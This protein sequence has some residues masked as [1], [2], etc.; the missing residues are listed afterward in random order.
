MVATRIPADIEHEAPV[1]SLVELVYQNEAG[2]VSRRRVEVVR[3]SH[4]RNGFTYLRA[5]C[6][7]REEER[8]FRA[9]RIRDW[10]VVECRRPV[11][12]KPVVT[13]V[14]LTIPEAPIEPVCREGP[15]VLAAEAP[16]AVHPVPAAPRRRR[17]GWFLSMLG[18]GLT[19]TLVRALLGEPAVLNTVPAPPGPVVLPA[20]KPAPRPL[21]VP[22]PKPAARPGAHP[23]PNPMQPRRVAPPN[24]EGVEARQRTFRAATGIASV[25]LE[26]LYEGADRNGDGA[27]DWTELAV[28]QSWLDRA[29]AYRANRLALRPDEFLAEGGGDCEDWALFSCGLLRYW[30]WDPYVGSFAGSEHGTG[31]AVCLVRVGGRPTR[32]QAW[33]VDADGWLGGQPVRAG[34]YVPVDYGVVG[35]L[36]NAVEDGWRLRVIWTPEQIYG[37][38]M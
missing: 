2:R 33:S 18:V 5:Y 16:I 35:G 29:Y 30:G 26:T 6:F 9:D 17:S 7:L 25:G 38:E 11:V 24:G 3:W 37:K 19:I 28:F 36:T 23:A 22:A 32:Y 1:G 13:F 14:P 31:H 27:L 15:A 4:A 8:T 21:V 12:T 10:Q 34:W 20:P